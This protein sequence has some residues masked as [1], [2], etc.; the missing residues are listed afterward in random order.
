IH[1]EDIKSFTIA[2]RRYGISEE[3]IETIRLYHYGDGTTDGSGSVRLDQ[4]STFKW[5]KDRIKK[6][7]QELNNSTEFIVT[8]FTHVLFRGNNPNAKQIDYLYVGAVVNGFFASRYELCF[9][10]KRDVWGLY[11]NLHVGPVLLRPGAR[12]AN[13]R[14]SSQETRNRMIVY[15]PKLEKDIEFIQKHFG[16]DKNPRF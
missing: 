10:V 11:D 1:S 3:T 13:K 6:A 8:F 14:I 7:N 12:Y 5:L 15:W 16:C 2:L 4:E 9:Y